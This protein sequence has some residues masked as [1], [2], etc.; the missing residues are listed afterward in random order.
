MRKF[1]NTFLVIASLVSIQNCSNADF[2]FSPNIDNKYTFISRDY[3]R[4]VAYGN[5][6]VDNIFTSPNIGEVYSDMDE[7]VFIS[8]IIEDD[9][10]LELDLDANAKKQIKPKATVIE[11]YKMETSK[12]CTE[13]VMVPKVKKYK[14]QQDDLIGDEIENIDIDHVTDIKTATLEERKTRTSGISK[15]REKRLVLWF[16]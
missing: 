15:R 16:V 9:F 5:I 4:L 7:N 6:P 10:N 13:K 2:G 8:K 1:I 3:N 11:G 14:I 12:K